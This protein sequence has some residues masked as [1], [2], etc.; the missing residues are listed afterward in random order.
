[1]RGQMMAC[2]AWHAPRLGTGTRELK[3]RLRTVAL[4]F[5][6]VSRRAWI[7]PSALPNRTRVNSLLNTEF[8]ASWAGGMQ[9][10]VSPSRETWRSRRQGPCYLCSHAR[11][12]FW[13][14]IEEHTSELQSLMR[15]SYAVFC[16]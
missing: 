9:G 8:R 12:L 4:G 5:E 2:T 16:L 10:M 11:R 14:K 15:I 6:A 13:S 3:L 1:M 7:S